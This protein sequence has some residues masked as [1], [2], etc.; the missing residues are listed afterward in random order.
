MHCA[1]SCTQAMCPQLLRHSMDATRV[2]GAEWPYP[3]ESVAQLARNRGFP[4]VAEWLLRNGGQPTPIPAPVR[5]PL[6]YTLYRVG[7]MSGGHA[8][9]IEDLLGASEA[10]AEGD[11]AETAATVT[12]AGARLHE[13]KHLVVLVVAEVLPHS[14][15][16]PLDFWQVP[17]IEGLQQAITPAALQDPLAQLPLTLFPRTV[18][19]PWQQQRRVAV[20]GPRNNG[21]QGRLVARS[22][23][24]AHVL[25]WKGVHCRRGRVCVRTGPGAC[26]TSQ[27]QTQSQRVFHGIARH[28][29]PIQHNDGGVQQLGTWPQLYRAQVELV[30]NTVQEALAKLLVRIKPIDCV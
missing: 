7:F 2:V 8:N 9:N 27:T 29:D 16:Q 4:R 18:R 30:H 6:D 12:A 20:R 24:L 19:G 5:L 15:V 17:I 14:F 21:L 23:R 25:P 13:A 26:V 22:A 28:L 3:M 1:D 11:D 10:T